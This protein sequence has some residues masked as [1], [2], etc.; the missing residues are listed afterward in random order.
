VWGLRRADDSTHPPRDN[1]VKADQY[2][3]DSYIA[4]CAS[5]FF[6][7]FHDV[8]QTCYAEYGNGLGAT[9]A[10]TSDT[11]NPRGPAG[12]NTPALPTASDYRRL[13]Y[14]EKLLRTNA[15]RI[16]IANCHFVKTPGRRLVWI[17]V[18]QGSALAEL[19]FW[20]RSPTEFCR[21]GAWHS[22]KLYRRKRH[23]SKLGIDL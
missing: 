7:T 9:F 10:V 18:V 6:L 3:T 1:H 11:R 19:V 13:C 22:S 15:I 21:V 12:R 16:F 2:L 5:W 4:K 17:L 23:K 8:P 20:Y 14:C